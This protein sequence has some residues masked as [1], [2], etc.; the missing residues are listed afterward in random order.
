MN[1]IGK[2]ID[3]L[4]ITFFGLS[5]GVSSV[6]VLKS[7]LLSVD[8]QLKPLVRLVTLISFVLN[9]QAQHR[10]STQDDINK[11]PQ[12][13]HAFPVEGLSVG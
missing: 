5:S 4:S 3:N 12:V 13:D 2:P 9:P 8:K 6:E 7:V 10:D 1:S 11:D